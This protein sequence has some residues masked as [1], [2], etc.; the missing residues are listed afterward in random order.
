MG[1]Q[2]LNEHKSF[3]EWQEFFSSCD[4]DQV[5]YIVNEALTIFTSKDEPSSWPIAIKTSQFWN[6]AIDDLLTVGSFSTAL[7]SEQAK[8]CLGLAVKLMTIF[9]SAFRAD[10]VKESEAAWQATID[11]G[12]QLAPHRKL[13]YESEKIDK[14][15]RNISQ[16]S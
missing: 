7:S 14:F 6:A 3:A 5:G 9:K 8:A 10:V 2:V 16:P 1:L 4:P 11:M 13:L 12:K 15:G